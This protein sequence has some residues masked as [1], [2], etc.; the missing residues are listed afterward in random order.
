MKQKYDASTVAGMRQALN[1]VIVD[2]RF[3]VIKSVTPLEVAD[4]ILRQAACYRP[5]IST[6]RKTDLEAPRIAIPRIMAAISGANLRDA[7]A[8]FCLPRSRK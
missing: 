1:E 2:R 8:T 7:D 4:H 6:D 5:R 3:L